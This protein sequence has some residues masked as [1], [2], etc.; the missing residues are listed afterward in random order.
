[1]RRALVL[2]LTLGLLLSTTHRSP[3]PIT[4]DSATP[5]PTPKPR[6]K[7]NTEPKPTPRPASKPKPT[8][9]SFA[10]VW[11]TNFN[12]EL[13]VSQAGDHVTGIYD[14]TRGLLDGTV[15]GDTVVGTYTWR[16]MS[17]IFRFLLATD[18]K[19]F[20]G[21]FNGSNGMGGAWTG[22]RRSH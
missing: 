10:G 7:R 2:C 12:N 15:S 6:V 4:E 16:G 20:S 17:G 14:G 1:M 19:S 18:G 22:I 13:R 8:P 5:A 21:T 9:V 11:Q 3:A